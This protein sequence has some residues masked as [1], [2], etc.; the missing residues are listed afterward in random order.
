MTD[1]HSSSFKWGNKE[2]PATKTPFTITKL[3]GSK[4]QR[5]RRQHSAGESF[6]ELS[7]PV[8]VLDGLE[9]IRSS[10]STYNGGMNR[11]KM[12]RGL[13]KLKFLLFGSAEGLSGKEIGE[14]SLPKK[15]EEQKPSWRCFSY[16]EISHATR[17]FHAD[18]MVG[19][20]GY[21][22]VF[23]GSLHGV[24]VAVKRLS[25]SN[26]EE[27]EREFLAELG[28][29]G[30]VCHPNTTS[31]KGC[32]F[33]NGFHLIFDFCPNGS[34]ASALHGKS[35]KLL[36]WTA[37]YRIAMGIARGIHYLHEGC[38]HR[39]I[40]RDIKASNVLLGSN[41]EPQISD[42]G[43]AK[44]L[45]KQQ[46]HHSVNPIEGTF[47]Y[48]APEYFMYGMVDE[49]TDVFA[50]GVLLLEIVTGKKPI[51]ASKQSLLVWAK[52]LMEAGK[53]TK[54]VDSRLGENYDKDQLKRL[55][56]IAS[57]C[58][59]PSPIWRP[60][61]TEVQQLLFEG[62]SWQEAWKEAESWKIPECH[63][64]DFDDFS[65]ESDICSAC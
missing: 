5:E 16:D 11:R 55:V 13:S 52:P 56:Q 48:L 60:S 17:N 57:Y 63:S 21:S 27:K 33:E 40:H 61:M 12:R 35:N 37:R 34:L 38:P 36:E 3:F 2:T 39:I 8:T 59:R 24:D 25:K 1:D 47:G 62:N 4:I 64:V 10:S 51:D 54:L 28:I 43:L 41:Y 26:R 53:F 6:G 7:S 50:F 58:V 46:T 44:W 29:L 31:L 15:Y 32:C 30:H 49:K 22:E 9:E 18:N 20:G 65:T 42:F 45:P 19:R 23:K 14:D